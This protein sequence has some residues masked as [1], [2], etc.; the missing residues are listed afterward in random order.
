LLLIVIVQLHS[1]NEYCSLLCCTMMWWC[2]DVA[3]MYI[4]RLSETLPSH[5]YAGLLHRGDEVLAVNRVSVIGLP[6]D[7]VF[8]MIAQSSKLVLRL[9]SSM[10]AAGHGTSSCWWC[11][12][13]I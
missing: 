11:E 9:R 5:L 10:P 4:S 3:V 13:H 2:R 6:L 8:D 12:G 1:D 7:T